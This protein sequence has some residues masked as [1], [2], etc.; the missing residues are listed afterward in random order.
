MTA[1]GCGGSA[2]GNSP[3][4]DRGNVATPAAV[5]AETAG[6]ARSGPRLP[7]GFHEPVSEHL[8]LYVEA[9]SAEIE[10]QRD[11]VPADDF[12]V[13]ADDLMFYRATAL[14]YLE[15][16]R[17]PHVRISGRRPIEF[18]VG[19]EVASYD[20]SD[21]MLLDFL[22]LYQPDEPPRVIAPNE[23][24]SEV[25]PADILPLPSSESL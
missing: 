21:V 24:Q 3:G 10:R 7:G 6:A 9:T 25:M 12:A 15:S 23:V 19:G 13:I 18:M 8:L 11:R 20:W 2:D 16:N 14:D 17:I 22:V 5:P 1:V 4:G